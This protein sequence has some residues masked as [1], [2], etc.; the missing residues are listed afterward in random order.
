MAPLLHALTVTLMDFYDYE[1]SMLTFS[2]GHGSATWNRFKL[3]LAVDAGKYGCVVRQVRDWEGA[4]ARGTDVVGWE[5]GGHDAKKPKTARVVLMTLWMIFGLY[6]CPTQQASSDSWVG[7]QTEAVKK[8]TKQEVIYVDEG[9]HTLKLSSVYVPSLVHC[10]R[11]MCS[12]RFMTV[13][14]ASLRQLSR[15]TSRQTP[16]ATPSLCAD[17]DVKGRL[18]LSPDISQPIKSDCAC[19][20]PPLPPVNTAFAGGN[21]ALW[22]PQALSH[23][24]VSLTRT[25]NVDSCVIQARSNPAPGFVKLPLIHSAISNR[26]HFPEQSHQSHA[27]SNHVPGRPT[28]QIV[29]TSSLEHQEHT[30]LSER[31]GDAF[32]Q[33]VEYHSGT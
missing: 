13:L 26:A 2:T 22:R 17:P 9:D 11:V 24:S 1:S 29:H 21:C 12:F 18:L 14:S 31:I 20:L 3:R 27:S 15:D 16:R 23:N 5:C 6:L 10:E 33:F 19:Y 32:D 25:E 8:R 4:G 30:S 7:L 28:V